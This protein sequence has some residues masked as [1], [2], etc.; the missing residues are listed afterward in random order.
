MVGMATAPRL[1]SYEE[2][3]ALEAKSESKHEYCQGQILDMA[4][5]TLEHSALAAVVT[6]L[7]GEGLRGRPCRVLSS[8]AR[9]RVDATDFT[10]YPDVSVACGEILRSPVDRH[11][12]TNPV[13]VVE[14][15]SESSEAYDRGLKFYH[16]RRIESLQEYLLVN[17]NAQ[18]LEL[19]RRTADG[20][21]ILHE[22]G[23]G[24]SVHVQGVT[25]AVDDVYRDP[26]AG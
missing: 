10:G 24:E 3:L 23:P 9:V 18:R 21:W 15:L 4:G 17:Q 7:L 6:T 1:A 8:D 2:Y 22:A 16:Y 25:I 12:C 20:D 5:G 19:Y 11:A 26:L 14:V 13:V